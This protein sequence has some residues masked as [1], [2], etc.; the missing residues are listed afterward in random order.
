M[1]IPNILTVIRI[2][3]T[4]IFVIAI[5]KNVY[6]F[7]LMI[8]AIAAI[9][10]ALDGLIARYLNQRTELGAQMDPVADKLLLSSA[11]ICLAIIHQIPNWL[12]VIVISRDVII[13]MG[14]SIC[15]ISNVYVPIKP[16]LVSKATT[17]SQL[18]TITL[19]LFNEYYPLTT[20]LCIFCWVTATLTIISGLHYVFIGMKLLHEGT[21]Q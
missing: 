10:D 19:A 11:Y 4:P 16:S 17:L 7:A 13:L 18:L 5:I 9:S 8:F 20:I 21:R 2:L 1:S 12:T 6:S 15:Y 14:M 3:L